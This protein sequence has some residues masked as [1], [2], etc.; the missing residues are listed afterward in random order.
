[1]KFRDLFV[2][3]YLHS[4]PE[5]RMKFVMSSND[6]KLLRQ[7]SEK[8]DDENSTIG[9]IYLE[10]SYG[11]LVYS[12]NKFSAIIGVENLVVVNTKDALL[13]CD[14]GR[15]QDVKKIVDYL[16]MHNRNELL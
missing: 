13:V 11:S 12:P 3:K 2:A 14:R 16:R 8:D 4:D 6:A 10:K 5:V 1:M 15:S 9:D 7:M